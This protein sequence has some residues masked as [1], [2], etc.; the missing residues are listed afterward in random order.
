[1][2]DKQTNNAYCLRDRIRAIDRDLEIERLAHNKR[3]DAL[4]DERDKLVAELHA[5]GFSVSV[6]VPSLHIGGQLPS[7]DPTAFHGMPK[8]SPPRSR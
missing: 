3:K 5:E 4:N 7:I 6:S 1:M 2:C 8:H